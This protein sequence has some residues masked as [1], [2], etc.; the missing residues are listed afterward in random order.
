MTNSWFAFTQ[1]VVT[2]SNSIPVQLNAN[3]SLKNPW[4]GGLNS[5][6]FSMF[7]ADFDGIDDDLFIFD[8]AGNRSLIF[9]GEIMDGQRVYSYTP[10]LSVD[11]PELYNWAL[12]RD[13]DCD[14]KKDIFTY[15][16]DGGAFSVYKNMSTPENQEFTQE[17][18][19][20]NSWYPF[21]GGFS[22]NIFVSTQDI[23]AIF[24][25][26]GDGDLD[27]LTF[28]VSGSTV[29]LHMNL[30]MEEFGTCSLDSMVLANRCYGKF[31]EA[32][33]DNG[34][35]QDPDLF[36]VICSFNVPDP[37]SGR[38]G[39]NVGGSRHI[40]STI[41]AFDATMDGLVDLVIGDV[42]FTNLTYLENS[43]GSGIDS[44]VNISDDFPFGF[45]E[46]PVDIDNFPAAFYEDISGD[47]VRDLLVGVNNGDVAAN[48]SSIWYYENTGLDNLPQFEYVQ[49]NFL[50][51]TTIDLGEASAPAMTD[52]NGDGLLD[53][54]VGARGEY[55]GQTMYEPT[56]S[57]FLNSGDAE[58]PS[59]ILD[60]QDLINLE[61][62]GIGQYPDPDF[63]DLDGDEDIDL[64]I[65]DNSGIIHFYEN[66]SSP[67]N[68][69]IL[70]YQGQLESN[71]EIIDVGQKS[72]PQLF[73]LD[74]DGLL[75]LIVGE[76][77]G[78]INYYRN[79]GTLSFPD[80]QFVTDTLGLLTT[81]EFGLF[82]GSSVPHF[83]RFEGETILAAGSES[84]SIHQYNNIDGNLDGT[85]DLLDLDGFDVQT[86][87]LNNSII[88]N[89]N[90]DEY[91]DI[92]SGGIGGGLQLFLGDGFLSTSN[93]QNTKTEL[94]K[95]YPNPAN[96]V[97]FFEGDLE[98]NSV[99]RIYAIDGKLLLED[100]IIDKVLSIN[101]LNKGIF[102][103]EVKSANRTRQFKLLKK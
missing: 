72:A 1:I 69:M 90:N 94:I 20:L 7:D 5:A 81:L 97:L 62:D 55:L 24:D 52:V 46:V 63:A 87:A 31:I 83:Y 39:T 75:D 78:N 54:V 11:V 23:P 65:G 35:I 6:Q 21:S 96:N 16:L 84:G 26:E 99:V 29:E 74:Q 71:G 38:P 85:F 3:N 64:V 58:N 10:Q 49:N 59:F 36:D 79:E 98:P 53:I 60:S 14:G 93:I 89:L 61:M 44:I 33:E 25:F 47:G 76:R 9:L 15:S 18:E 70:S 68:P 12:L 40:G 82:V 66:T 92:I 95:V 42:G 37:K 88:V 19:T 51:N 8:K 34:I 57:V 73:D 102:I 48:K 101:E 32:S 13:F 86:G 30:S 4:T 43:E 2:P 103:G 27:I 22:T 67:G 80:F 45:S 17:I 28:G 50:Q 77:N 56:I 100:R 41:L 91:F